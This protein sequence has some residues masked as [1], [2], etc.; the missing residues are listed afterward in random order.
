MII[1]R[2]A[3]LAGTAAAAAAAPSLRRLAAARGIRFGSE[4]LAPEIT[5]DA[6]YAALV[7]RQ[8]AMVVPGLEAK[9]DHVE[10]A[11]GRFD[12][13]GLDRIAAYASG[14]A[15][16]LRLHTLVWGLAMPAWLG[17]AL[18]A[19]RGEA[20]LRRHIAAVVGRYRGRVDSWDVVNEVADPRWPAGPEGLTLTPWRRAL[21]PDYVALA[22]HLTAAADPAARLLVNDDDLEYAT[23]EAEA[24]RRRYLRL[25]EG[26]VAAGVPI[27]GF[28]LQ[29]HLKPDRPI[30]AAAYRSWLAALAG[31]GLALFVTELDVQDRSLPA[32]RAVRDRIVADTCRRYLDIALDEPAVR[33]VLTWGLTGRY[34]YLNTD[35]RV[36]RADGLRAR[37][38]PYDA[39]L[40]RTPMWCALAQAFRDAPA[41]S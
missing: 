28:G 7:A 29:A 41:R 35:A 10:P 22:F 16:A 13:T 4:I 18:Q 32:D 38:L 11:D 25:L 15:L 36:R 27:G 2:R 3:L 31:M 14:N 30:A 39:A 19:G 40:R 26:W 23:P 24:K 17:P 5:G 34:S 8:C 21:G 20:V 33:A 6:A 12:F 37:G 1:G 9:W